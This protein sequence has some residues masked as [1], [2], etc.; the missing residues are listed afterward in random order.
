M[1]TKVSKASLPNHKL[2]DPNSEHQREEFYY[3]L[4]LLFVPFRDESAL[5]NDNESAEAAFN[6]HMGDNTDLCAHHGKLQLILQAQAKVKEINE[7]REMQNPPGS[8]VEEDIFVRGEPKDALEDVFHLNERPLEVTLQSR[9]V[10]LNADQLHVFNNITNH[11]RHQSNNE[12]GTCSCDKLRPLNM[13]LSGV[14]G[15]GKSFLIH[16]IRAQ[17]AQIWKDIPDALMCAIAAPTGL[18][19]FNIGGVTVHHLFQLPV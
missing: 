6:R 1:Y 4:M 7:V 11:L 16:T 2:F 14:G 17:I 5:I 12:N 19:A 13:F 8:N 10:M 3:S 9:I 18:A 15:T